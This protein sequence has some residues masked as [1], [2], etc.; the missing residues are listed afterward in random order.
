VGSDLRIKN[1]DSGEPANWKVLIV[2][3]TFRSSNENARAMAGVGE[4]F[5][6]A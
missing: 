5:L 6:D 1:F 3:G 4:A 2:R